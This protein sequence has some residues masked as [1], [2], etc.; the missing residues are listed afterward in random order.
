MVDVTI[1]SAFLAG[2]V[3]FLAPC[4]LPLVPAYLAFLA[5]SET[6]E[7][8]Q[9]VKKA[10]A[11]VSGFG[12]AIVILALF[13]SQIGRFVSQYRNIL[14]SIGG[15]LFMLFGLSL[16]RVFRI[17]L[18]SKGL[19]TFLA[20]TS[21]F[22]AF[23]L[24]FVFTFG[25]SP[26]VGPILGSIYVLAAQSGSVFLGT[27]LLLAYVLGHSIPFLLLAFFYERSFSIVK[28]LSRYTPYVNTFAGIVLVVIGFLMM[29]GKFGL[30]FG[31]FSW[32][33]DG[34]WQDILTRFL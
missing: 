2:L 12:S 31:F 21:H 11:F 4:T 20:P 15:I 8:H 17:P 29:I 16:L 27:T 10:F 26:C 22:A 18:Q 14:L 30:V 13:V 33:F 25:W 19:P 5:G 34:S 6:P 1:F 7:R 28:T 32:V 3:T 23:L 24:G 9:I